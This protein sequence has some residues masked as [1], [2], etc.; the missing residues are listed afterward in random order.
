[1]SEEKN[2]TID[3]AVSYISNNYSPLGETDQKEY[4]TS[5]DIVRELSE[6]VS[7]SIADITKLMDDAGFKIEFIDGKP[8]WVVFQK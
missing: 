1:M 3:I 8:H 4:V 5:A 7:V 2:L 6:M